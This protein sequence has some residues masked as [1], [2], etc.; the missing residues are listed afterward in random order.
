HN[1]MDGIDATLHHVK[2]DTPVVQ[3]DCKTAFEN[4]SPNE[5]LYAHYIARASFE[6]ALIDFLQMSPESAGI[7]VVLHR[8]FAAESID[9]LKEKALS[10]GFTGEE[11]QNFLV[12]SAAL[13]ASHGNYKDFGD[14]K[15]IPVVAANKLHAFVAS[16]AA[17]SLSPDLLS[18][19]REVESAIYSLT[20]RTAGLGFNDSGV[21]T[22]HSDNVTKDDSDRINRF[23]KEKNLEAWN[24]R[25]FKEVNGGQTTLKIKIAS[26]NNKTGVTEDGEFEGVKVLQEKGDYAPILAKTCVHLSKAA[27]FAATPNQKAMMNKYVEHFNSGEIKD[28]KDASRMWIKDV[29]P[30]VESYMGFIE[31]YRDPAGVRSEFEGFVAVVNKETSKKFAH[32]VKEAETIIER[33]P[34]GKA[35]EKDTFLKPDFTALDVLAFGVSGIP[36]GIN[37]PNYDDIRQNEGFKNVSLSNVISAQPKQKIAFISEEDEKLLFDYNGKA[38]EVQVGLHELLGH[39]SG[40]LFQRNADGSFNFDKEKTVDVLTGGKVTSWYEPGETFAGVFGQL[41]CAYE[42]CRAEAVGYTLSCAPDILKI[43]GHEGDFGQLIKYVNWLGSIKK[44]L[45]ALEMYN[46]DTKKWGQAHSWARYVLMN[47]V[48]EAGQGFVTIDETKDSSGADDLSF[49]LDKTKIDSVGVPAVREFLKKLQAY[50]STADVKGAT[51]LFYKYGTVGPKALKWREIVIAKRLPR[52]MY[53]QANT[54]LSKD[55]KTVEMV[56]YPETAEG[57]IQSFVERY[58]SASIDDLCQLWKADQKYFPRAYGK[59]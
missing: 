42:E 5:R 47:V 10:A 3:L 33:L 1:E 53:L 7:F 18:I 32:L 16:S 49:K 34:W 36:C 40:K 43:F 29:G 31:N 37:I 9:K 24:T 54:K 11:W 51:E 2:N 55:E 28:H 8:I 58:S 13:Y 14:S 20:K 57:M 50:K 27:E 38:F 15:F 46:A 23:M 52:A 26:T 41:S 44:G 59:C 19:Y 6:G 56:T 45:L 30:I 22:Y 35:Y 21:T 4:L 39:G 17:A 25:L 48:L 12:W